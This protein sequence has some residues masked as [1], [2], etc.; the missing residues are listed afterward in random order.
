M[1][2]WMWKKENTA[3]PG[4]SSMGFLLGVVKTVWFPWVS[5]GMS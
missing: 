5:I 2:L 3:D 1:F 4:G